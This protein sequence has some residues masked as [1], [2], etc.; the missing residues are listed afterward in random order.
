MLWSLRETETKGVQ[1][2]GLG[3]TVRGR[4]WDMRCGSQL[5]LFPGQGQRGHQRPLQAEDVEGP[6]TQGGQS[7][8]FPLQGTEG[9]RAHWLK[10]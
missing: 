6:G 1:L 7:L 2:R 4:G 10:R 3:H 9:R 8:V 5:T